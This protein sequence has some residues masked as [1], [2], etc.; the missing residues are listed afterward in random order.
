MFGAKPKDEDP[1]V[2][3]ALEDLS[4]K[5]TVDDD[6]DFRFIFGLE[7]GRSQVGFIRSRTYE[8]AG[9]ELREIFSPALIVEGDF[10]QRTANGL[11]QANAN[12]KVGAWEVQR[13]QTRAAAVFCAKVSADLRGRELLAVIIGVLT[14]ADDM[15]KR[16]GAGDAF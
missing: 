2:R 8:F 5:F 4:L 10:D 9:V 3:S 13:T 1:R 7:N 6:G 16:Y 12:V 11:L 14:T 15:E